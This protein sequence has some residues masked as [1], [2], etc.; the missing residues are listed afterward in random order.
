MRCHGEPS[1]PTCASAVNLRFRDEASGY[2]WSGERTDRLTSVCATGRSFAIAALFLCGM[3]FAS[4][5]G[6]S[7]TTSGAPDAGAEDAPVSPQ[8]DSWEP[9]EPGSDRLRETSEPDPASGS[10]LREAEEVSDQFSLHLPEIADA[11]PVLA[12]DREIGP[13]GSTYPGLGTSDGR[14]QKGYDVVE[15][16][17]A[18]LRQGDLTAELVHDRRESSVR[19]R[20]QP[21]IDGEVS[22]ERFRIGVSETL[23]DGV[24]VNVRLFA[25]ETVREAIS[26]VSGE[27]YLTEDRAVDDVQIDFRALE[28]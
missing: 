3:L 15:D 20:V 12:A 23:D 13:L 28:E 1:L 2:A 21:V 27:V 5:G 19:R 7:A 26:S 14:Q 25:E 8:D 24:S 16:F 10:E 18:A 4:C 11:R 17:L 22:F 9:P 6:D